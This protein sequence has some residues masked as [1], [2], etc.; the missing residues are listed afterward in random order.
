MRTVVFDIDCLRPDHLGCYAYPRP[1]S[2][3][4]DAILVERQNGT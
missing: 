2:P 4:F 1:T 3:T